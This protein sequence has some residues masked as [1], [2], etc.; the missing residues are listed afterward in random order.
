M[1]RPFRTFVLP[2]S[3]FAAFIPLLLADGQSS[4]A[5][6]WILFPEYALSAEAAGPVGPRIPLPASLNRTLDNPPEPYTFRGEL[7][8]QRWFPDCG[9]SL[10]PP[11]TIELWTTDHSHYPTGVAFI[12][13]DALGEPLFRAAYYDNGLEVR[14]GDQAVF[15]PTEWRSAF[16]RYWRHLVLSVTAD[17]QAE[18]FYNGESIG[19]MEWPVMP[20]K[21]IPEIAAYTRRDPLMRVENLLH[22]CRIYGHALD[23][24]EVREAFGELNTLVFDGVRYPDLFHFIA[25]PAISHAAPD[26]I[27]LSCEADRPTRATVFWGKDEASLENSSG[28]STF[29]GVHAMVVNGLEAD[30]T[31]F[32]RVELEDRDGNKIDSGLLSFRTAPDTNRAVTFA[33]LG[34]TESRPWINAAVSRG[35]WGHGV[36]FAVHLG[37]LTDNGRRDRKPQWTHEYFAG[38]TPLQSRVAVFPVPGNGEGDDLYWFKRYFPHPRDQGN[39]P[40]FYRFSYGPVDFFMLNSNA[41]GDEFQPGGL[42]YAWLAGQLEQSEATWKV[43]CFHHVGTPGTFGDNPEV[44]ALVPLF[45]RYE[46]DF[47]LNGHKHAYERSYPRRAGKIDPAGTRYIVSGGAGGNLKDPSGSG[48]SSFTESVYRG[49]HYI[50]VEADPDR[51]RLTMY[52]L[53]G[54][55]RDQAT[56]RKDQLGWREAWPDALDSGNSGFVYDTVFGWIYAADWP[57]SFHWDLSGKWFFTIP[58]RS[59]RNVSGLLH[60]DY[61]DDRWLFTSSGIYPSYYD[62][63]QGDWF[64]F[65]KRIPG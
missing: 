2:L 16:N 55:A 28:I 6:D 54:T 12:A 24:G 49:Y 23:R 8:T 45:D 27:F 50:I 32:Y 20:E 9:R 64:R 7:P 40:G 35:I 57:W 11:F 33:V 39:R 60:F 36:D 43:V 19:T 46:V 18:V 4:P 59:G 34:D 30:Q 52:D 62:Y 31:Y 63:N 10:Q 5:C 61:T 44:N 58:V 29:L 48:K 26:R 22:R 38:M 41:R 65:M 25:G 56:V 15:H 21:V 47:V 37:D 17:R 3:F 13:R 42:Q 51:F 1:K 14:S 53:E